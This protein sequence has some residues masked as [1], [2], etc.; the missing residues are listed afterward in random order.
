M[1][2]VC[3]CCVFWV[4]NR[5]C[6]FWGGRLQDSAFRGTSIQ[7]V[8]GFLSRALERRQHEG[9]DMCDR[10]REGPS[11]QPKKSQGSFA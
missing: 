9:M 5:F 8:K 3:F 6:I 7:V 1:V 11:D 4:L 2:F 10:E